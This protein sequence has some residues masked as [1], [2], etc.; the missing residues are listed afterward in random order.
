MCVILNTE[1]PSRQIV[2]STLLCCLLY[3]AS[4][5]PSKTMRHWAEACPTTDWGSCWGG[6]G[7]RRQAGSNFCWQ[8]EAVAAPKPSLYRISRVICGWS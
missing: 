4:R 5:S 7:W 1:Y 3:N 8:A 2:S 6:R